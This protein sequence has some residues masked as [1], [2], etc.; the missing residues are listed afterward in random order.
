MSQDEQ[1]VEAPKE[2][3]LAER[4]ASAIRQTAPGTSL[5]VALDMIL[6]G[7]LGALICVGDEDAVLEAGGDGFPLDISFTANR[8]FELSKMD[9]AIVVDGDL[10]TILRAN[11][12]L[13]PDPGLPTSETG[14]RHRTASRMSLLTKATVISISQRRQV[15]NLYVDGRAIQL[16][17]VPELMVTVNRLLV[18]LQQAR[19][20]LDRQLVRLSSL[21]LDG[22]VTLAD[23]TNTF[24]NFEIL[25]MADEELCACLEELGSEGRTVELQRE[26]FVRGMDEDYTLMVRDYAADSSEESA[27]E[28][29]E[30]LHEL[31]QSRQFHSSRKVAE[32]LGYPDLDEDSM[33]AP[34]GLRTLARVSVV[35]EGMAEQIIDEYGSLQEVV[36]DMGE[37]PERLDEIGVNNPDVLVNSLTRLMS[38]N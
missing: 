3:T 6:A 26:Q 32:V 27:R 8:L 7:H 13:N 12:H 11:F 1:K 35:R 9:G 23:V 19:Q 31:A 28:V 29:R 4:R 14:M 24:S 10:N 5:R 18:T 33:M 36:S 16:R 30:R 15:I 25:L 34:L 22:F 38:T 37:N 2:P 21:E 17:T 20:T